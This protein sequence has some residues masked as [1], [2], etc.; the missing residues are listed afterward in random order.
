MNETPNSG[1]S[2]EYLTNRAER[3]ALRHAEISACRLNPRERTWK[4]I[5]RALGRQ[6]HTLGWP[7]CP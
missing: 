7:Y 6:A 4:G 1:K 2:L 3:M 5:V